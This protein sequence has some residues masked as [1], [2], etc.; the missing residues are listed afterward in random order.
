MKN[1]IFN[2]TEGFVERNTSNHACQI[3]CSKSNWNYVSLIFPLPDH[4]FKIMNKMNVC[5]AIP[6]SF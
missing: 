6:V 5:S 2:K 1:I 4:V 3:S